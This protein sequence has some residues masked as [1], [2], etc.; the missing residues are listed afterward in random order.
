MRVQSLEKA[1]LCLV[2]VIIPLSFDR[3]SVNMFNIHI[4]TAPKKLIKKKK[5][6]RQSFNQGC[7]NP[8]G[9][10]ALKFLVFPWRRGGT[11]GLFKRQQKLNIWRR[12]LNFIT[13]KHAKNY[14]ELSINGSHVSCIELIFPITIHFTVAVK[15]W[16]SLSPGV[17]NN[18]SLVKMSCA[19]NAARFFFFPRLK[20]FC[21]NF[22]FLYLPV[23]TIFF[24]LFYLPRIILWYPPPPSLSQKHL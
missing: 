14:Y 18:L 12:V 13:T 7:Y 5:P 19:V 8:N 9:R 2:Y 6:V 21:T 23:C 4:R 22:C 1:W 11:K 20:I 10:I 24:L 16:D 3:I 15:P 17:W